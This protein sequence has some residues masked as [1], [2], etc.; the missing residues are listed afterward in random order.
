MAFEQIQDSDGNWLRQSF[1]I[2][3]QKVSIID[4]RKQMFGE[5][6][7]KFTDTTLGGN[8]AINS[9]PQRTRYADLRV[10]GRL[11]NNQNHD[12]RGMG[13]YYS[14]AIDDNA[15]LIN[16][17]FGL[18]EFNSLTT[19]FTSFY[20]S[21]AGLLARTGRAPNTGYTIG[22]A[23]GFIATI[24]FAPI[25]FIGSSIRFLANMPATK[26]YYLKPSMPLYWNAVNT[27]VNALAVDLHMIPPAWGDEQRKV[28]DAAKVANSEIEPSMDG[29]IPTADDTR[30]MSKLFADIAPDI[31]YKNGG[32]DIYAVANKATRVSVVHQKR[33]RE[34]MRASTDAATLQKNINAYMGETVADPG[35]QYETVGDN[36]LSGIDSSLKRWSESLSGSSKTKQ[37]LDT[38]TEKTTRGIIDA[39]AATGDKAIN[40]IEAS[41]NSFFTFYEAERRD[42]SDWV[43]FRVNNTGPAS[44]SFSNETRDSDLQSKINSTSSQAREAR[45][46]FAEG[47]FGNGIF[48]IVEE[49]KSQAASVVSGVADSLSMSGLAALAGSAFVDIPQH[50]AA[51]T[52]SLPS[53]SFTINLRSPYGNKMSIYQNIHVP[54]AMLLAGVLPLSTG[55]HSYTSPFL[56]E[57]Y[58]QGRSQVRLGIIDSMSITRGVGNLGWSVDQLPLGVDVTFSIKDLSSIMHMPIAPN[59]SLN[60]TKGVFDD[61]N[62]FNDYLAVLAGMSLSDQIYS[63]DHKLALAMARK[64]TSFRQW[65][66]AAKWANWANGTPP[67]RFFAAISREIDRP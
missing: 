18:P 56:V 6:R 66:S 14:E 11:V 5:A 42:G 46:N 37:T 15:Q 29:L 12:G 54:L 61:D 57:M 58:N 32:I 43:T 22:R 62:S 26:F 25:L 30:R 2:P 52:A 59:F 7:F 50:W 65:T 44:E 23:I 17:R 20:N 64:A 33:V 51:A 27:I 19:F 48:N 9:P 8:F 67:G 39:I 49:V 47:N 4:Q 34:I 35:I 36:T 24:P 53:S 55:N 21:D 60:P 10:S 16:M 38:S 40:G 13:R 1:M 45:F 28:V 31:F 63:W 41:V 3:R